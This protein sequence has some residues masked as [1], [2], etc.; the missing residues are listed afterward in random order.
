VLALGGA[1]GDRPRTWAELVA[2]AERLRRRIVALNWQEP[3]V[4]CCDRFSLL[5]VLL[6]LWS[7]GRRAVLANN[8]RVE[9]IRALIDS[10]TTDGLL[11]DDVA[12]DGL[13]GLDVTGLCAGAADATSDAAL[14]AY[15]RVLSWNDDRPIVAIYSSG[16][17]GAPTRSL[18]TAR[19]IFGEARTLVSTFA[20]GAD[21]RVLATAPPHHI[22]GLLF[23]VLVP[24]FA[25]GAF[26]RQTPLHAESIAA[27]ALEHGADVLC[28]VPAHLQG[29]LALPGGSLAGL[30]SVFSSGAAL[31]PGLGATLRER[32]ALRI[33]EV[34]GSSETGGMAWRIADETS[35]WTPLPGV[36]VARDRDGVLL[37]D[38]PFLPPDAPR[39]MRGAD[40]VELTSNGR[41]RHLGRADGIVKVGGERVSLLEIEHRLLALDGV[42]DA[43]VLAL[44]VAGPRQHEICAAVVAPGLSAPELRR[45]LSRWFDPVALPRRFKLVERLPREATGKLQR[46]RLRT[47]FETDQGRSG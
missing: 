30:G 41:F 16:S 29:L 24:V 5:A 20:L 28:A 46:A 19:Q 36:Q 45:G 27:L 21:C 13:P 1:P 26:V 11:H 7:E 3:V 12:L 35:E 8:G 14:E 43:A 25:G 31:P 37:V 40:R 32:F 34:L 9:T 18:K 15:E 6:A 23:G 42:S 47:L 10:A 2:A 22:Y 4:S 38:S 17:T 39:P 33:T 44:E